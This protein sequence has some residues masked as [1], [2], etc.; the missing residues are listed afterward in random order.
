MSD[1][2]Q[3]PPPEEPTRY[4]SPPPPPAP[5]TQPGY[6]PPPPGGGYQ[7]AS[8]PMSGPA[9]IGQPAELMVRVLARLLD[10]LL[11]GIVNFF[12][13]GLLLA[14]LMN[15]STSNSYSLSTGTSYAVAALSGVISAILYVGYF[16]LMESRNGQ[17][18]G[19]MVL[20]LRTQGPNGATPTTAEA[21][22]R[23]AWTG[24]GVLRVIPFGGLVGGL[25]ELTAVIYIMVTISGSPTRQGW[26][27]T[28]A[29]GTQVIRIG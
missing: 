7:P 16:T 6:P 25:L 4:A 15:K 12:I 27:D 20:K 2:T 13:G 21:F 17:T 9:G 8:P 3:E 11:V 24:L 10:F 28:F 5:E 14:A 29:G 19:K 18:V 26:H 1:S 23:N 22:K